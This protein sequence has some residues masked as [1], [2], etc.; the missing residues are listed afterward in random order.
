MN[1]QEIIKNIKKT[2]CN[3]GGIIEYSVQV[4]AG[5]GWNYIPMA[6]NEI[7]LC[8]G[9]MLDNLTFIPFEELDDS[10]LEEIKEDIKEKSYAQLV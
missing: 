10:E 2:V 6:V 8:H 1:R 3:N 4:W 5:Y 7:G 9:Y